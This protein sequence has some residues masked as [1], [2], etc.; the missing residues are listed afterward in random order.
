MASDEEF[1]LTFLN[2]AGFILESDEVR[3]VS[4]PWMQGT[5]FRGSWALLDKSTQNSQLLDYLGASKKRTFLWYSHEHA[6]HFDVQ[7]LKQIAARFPDTTVLYQ[8]TH[9]H[10]VANFVRANGLQC[11]ESINKTLDLGNGLDISIHKSGGGDSWIVVNAAGKSLVNL[12]DCNVAD[13]SKCRE[14]VDSRSPKL[15]LLLTQFGYASWVGNPDQPE[16][17]RLRAE[18]ILGRVRSQIVTLQPTFTVP[19]ASFAMFCR[20]DN[21]YLNE[22]QSSVNDVLDLERKGELPSKILV[23][24]PWQVIRAVNGSERTEG[25]VRAA[26]EWDRIRVRRNEELS[27]LPKEPLPSEPPSLQEVHALVDSLSQFIRESNRQLFFYPRLLELVGRTKPISIWVSDAKMAVRLSYRKAEASTHRR[28]EE[29]AIAVNFEWLASAISTP[30]GVDTLSIAGCFQEQRVVG[31]HDTFEFFVPQ[32]LLRQGLGKRRP[33]LT[34]W[35]FARVVAL[36]A[37]GKGSRQRRS[38]A[39]EDA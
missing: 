6:D 21:K 16:R 11:I 2:H 24:R 27:D 35:W 26:L 38:M 23:P 12:N 31:A 22:Q 7:L 1:T 8:A 13:L 9:D 20:P 39:E 5:A 19:F 32:S 36:F 3:L 30:Y 4:D 10:R 18:E 15:D 29:C 17:H 37:L 34:L 14:I 25:N 28:E 33:I